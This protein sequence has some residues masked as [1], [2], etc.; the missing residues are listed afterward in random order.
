MHSSVGAV[1]T[2]FPGGMSLDQLRV[3]Y[4]AEVLRC[5]LH[6]YHV[7]SACHPAWSEQRRTAAR[8]LE[9]LIPHRQTELGL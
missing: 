6:M 9:A 8:L 7:G 1:L 2:D 4:R 3:A 5:T